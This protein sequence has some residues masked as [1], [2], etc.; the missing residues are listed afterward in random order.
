[1]RVAAMLVGS[2]GS[3]FGS[4]LA[5][6][7]VSTDAMLVLFTEG[8][9]VGFLLLEAVLSLLY[10][11]ALAASITVLLR[12][13]VG[14]ILLLVCTIGVITFGGLELYLYLSILG[15]PREVSLF[16]SPFLYP[17]IAA[18]F[19]LAASVLAFLAARV[20]QRSVA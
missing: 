4:F 19:L 12:L 5:A 2:A 17:V 15:Y 10:L 8:G 20:S 9:S 6:R 3:L 1:M 18:P 14:V 16:A 13:G 11:A 7:N